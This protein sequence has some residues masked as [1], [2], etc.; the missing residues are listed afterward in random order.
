MG[1]GIWPLIGGN[2]RERGPLGPRQMIS[3]PRVVLHPTAL[4]VLRARNLNSPAA[5]RCRKPRF[6]VDDSERFPGFILDD[7]ERL[8]GFRVNGIK[9]STGFK[10]NDRKQLPGAAVPILFEPQTLNLKT[11]TPPPTPKTSDP[12]TLQPNPSA[13]DPG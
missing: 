9:P 3:P 2:S 4:C 1:C 6:I 11:H 10:M 13:E 12:Q 7:S 8:P 5:P